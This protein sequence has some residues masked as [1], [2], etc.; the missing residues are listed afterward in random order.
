VYVAPALVSF[1]V[2][3]VAETR[4][5]AGLRLGA[6]PRASNALALA[7]RACA[8]LEGRSFMTADDVK[9]MAP[10]VLCHRLLSTPEA[11]L[12]GDSSPADIVATIL[13]AL[14]VPDLPAAG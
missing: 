7:S 4:T 9:A 5:A 10:L 12:E 1:I 11:A 6:S 13:R 3:I 2:S 8:A 14:P